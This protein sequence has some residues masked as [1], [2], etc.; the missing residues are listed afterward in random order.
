VE[1]PASI[2]G[3]GTFAPATSLTKERDAYVITLGSSATTVSLAS[4]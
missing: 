2:S 4:K 1:Q 3:V